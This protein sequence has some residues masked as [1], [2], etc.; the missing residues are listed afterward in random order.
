[1]NAWPASGRD[2]STYRKTGMFNLGLTL[3]QFAELEDA[4]RRR[5]LPMSTM[6][7]S[8]LLECLDHERHASY[9]D[10]GSS[11]R[12]SLCVDSKLELEMVCEFADVGHLVCQAPWVVFDRREVVMS[13]KTCGRFVKGIDYN[14]SFATFLG[15]VKGASQ[16]VY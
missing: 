12:R 1:M 9:R 3:E 15:G 13:V 6:A 14:K 16:R 10:H 4:A 8:W 11:I 7:R 5:H 2:L